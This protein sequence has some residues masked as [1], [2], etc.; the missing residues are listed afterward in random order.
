MDPK[1][2]LEGGPAGGWKKNCDLAYFWRKLDAE[3]LPIILP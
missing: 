3:G 2:W 1:H